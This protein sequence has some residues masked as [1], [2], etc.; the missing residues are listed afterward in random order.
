[1][2]MLTLNR[3]ENLFF[4]QGYD[5]IPSNLPEFNFYCRRE[6]QGITVLHV[7]DYRQGLYI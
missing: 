3:L 1:M 7:I 4:E 5:K 2:D 6:V